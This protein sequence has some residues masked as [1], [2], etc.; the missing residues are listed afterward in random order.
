LPPRRKSCFGFAAPIAELPPMKV[1][2][3]ACTPTSQGV[4]SVSL[5]TTVTA[6]SGRPSSSHT[7][8]AS[9][10]SEP[11]PISEAPVISVTC[12]KSSILRIVPQ[13]SDG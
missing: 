10:V 8:C 11:C 2:R 9:T 6:E 13:P 5:F 1:V 4:M 12:A 3:E 7:S